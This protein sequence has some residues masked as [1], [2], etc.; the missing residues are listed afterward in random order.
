MVQLFLQD[1]FQ[2]FNLT[3]QPMLSLTIQ[4][5]LTALKTNCCSEQE[6]QNVNCPVCSDSFGA[7]A[8]QLPNSHHVNSSLVCRLSGKLMDESNPPL[9][10]PNGYCYSQNVYW[11]NQ[12]LKQMQEQLGKIVCP[13][14]G[15][16]FQLSETRKAYIS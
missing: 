16:V 5:G 7:I 8:K 4:A 14:T 15:G 9:V 13:R 10:L 1:N 12:A 11:F 3:K 6:S 2:L